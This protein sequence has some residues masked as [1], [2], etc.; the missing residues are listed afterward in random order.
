[1]VV[2]SATS[3]PTAHANTRRRDSHRLRRPPEHGP[4]ALSTVVELLQR[5]SFAV[6]SYRFGR[7]VPFATVL[8]EGSNHPSASTTVDLKSV[9]GLG[10]SWQPR[11]NVVSWGFVGKDR[12]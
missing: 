12:R 2:T 8:G 6:I 7:H 11:D 9:L 1:M 4:E 10:K 3:A 5:D